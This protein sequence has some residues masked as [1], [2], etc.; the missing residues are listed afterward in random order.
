MPDI[1]E[2]MDETR[3]E[4]IKRQNREAQKR[5]ADKNREAV[6]ART[7]AWFAANKGY[8]GPGK[9]ALKAEVEA[10]R[11]NPCMDCGGSFPV[12]CMDFDH[13]R[14]E[15]VDDVVRLVH[16]STREAVMAEIEK[17]ELV[18]ANCHRIRTKQRRTT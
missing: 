7:R 15:K 13:V 14:G 6:R 17:C 5:Y 2:R 10:L 18:C 12:E 3:E 8:V 9:L 11:D 4:R 1:V 16:S